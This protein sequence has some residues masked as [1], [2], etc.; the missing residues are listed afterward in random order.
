MLFNFKSPNNGGAL[1]DLAVRQAISYAINR[2]ELVQDA[3]GPTISPAQTH[4][5]PNG[6]EGSQNFDL[7]PYNPAKAK[8]LLGSRKLTL[9]MLYQSDSP[10]QSEMFQS[11]QANLQAVGIKLNGIGTPAADIYTKY[12]EVPAV[13][14]RGVWDLGLTSWYPDWYGN[15]AVNYLLP[16]FD[17]ASFPPESGNL[18]FFS[19]ATVN[20]LIKQGQTAVSQSAADQ[21]WAAADKA[22]VQN[23][24]MYPI[25]SPEFVGFH[26]ALVHNVVYVPYLAQFDPANVWLSK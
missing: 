11:I 24:A 13:A 10:I 7:Y 1:Q 2:S 6:V 25:T 19:N 21:D 16:M 17:G 12:L 15:N 5:L 3:G 26:S 23:V 14:A 8:A 18:G 20:K 9:T 22:I 4:V